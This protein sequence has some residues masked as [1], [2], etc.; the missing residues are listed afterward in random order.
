MDW[1]EIRNDYIQGGGTYREL[2][3]KWGVPLRTLAKHA[4][5]DK[6]V[7]LK[8]QVNNKAATLGVEAAA[9]AK[10]DMATRL[11][12]AAGTMLDKVLTAAK[13]AKTAKEIRALTAAIKDIKDITGIKS[14]ADQEE[15]QA[16]I[17]SIR[18]KA[19]FGDDDDNDT[20]VIM[21]P[22]RLEADDG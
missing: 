6:W 7:E 1:L 5:V 14:E 19:A 16:R 8:Q 15:Q 2:A 4:K 17:A 22:P 12:D 9:Q 21:L 13:S 10:A 20:G 11:Y 18:A 3:A